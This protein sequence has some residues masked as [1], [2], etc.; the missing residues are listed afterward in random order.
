MHER[1]FVLE[2]FAEIAPQVVHPIQ[3][4]T[5]VELWDALVAEGPE[6]ETTPAEQSAGP[7]RLI[8]A[9]RNQRRRRVKSQ[10]KHRWNWAVAA[11]VTGSTRGI[12]RAIAL[13]LAAAG[14]EVIVHGRNAEQAE[15]V[16]QELDELGVA[17]EYIVADLAEP[18]DAGAWRKPPGTHGD[19]LMFGSTTPA[20]MCS[21]VSKPTGRFSVNFCRSCSTWTLPQPCSWPAMWAGA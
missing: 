12:G 3:G 10:K 20:Q 4:K 1:A 6:E 14:A 21:P 11:L 15:R 19:L 16:V 5:I 2:P 13:E 17:L 8:A 9:R 18:E 7:A